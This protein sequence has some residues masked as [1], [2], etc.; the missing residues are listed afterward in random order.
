MDAATMA[1]DVSHAS[2][3]SAHQK[4]R[5]TSSAGV[6]RRYSGRFPDESDEESG[7]RSRLGS[8]VSEHAFTPPRS[9]VEIAQCYSGNLTPRGSASIT[10]RFSLRSPRQT[11]IDDL[12]TVGDVT[13]NSGG[14][15]DGSGVNASSGGLMSASPIKG[16]NS[17]I[18]F[19]MVEAVFILNPSLPEEDKQMEQSGHYVSSSE[20][21]NNAN[22]TTTVQ[23]STTSPG[24]MMMLAAPGLVIGLRDVS[25]QPSIMPFDTNSPP[26]SWL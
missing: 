19:P 6:I 25:P 12:A 2:F 16:R 22:S 5:R 11:M 21:S 8:Y 18:N 24:R 10:P 14:S 4:L 26:S 1:R 20:Y 15:G 3:A 17:F 13:C 23:T 7:R 9:S